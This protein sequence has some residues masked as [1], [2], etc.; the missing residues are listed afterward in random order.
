[1]RFIALFFIGMFFCLM[2]LPAIGKSASEENGPNAT[3]GEEVQWFDLRTILGRLEAEYDRVDILS[4]EIRQLKTACREMDAMLQWP[5]D[6]VGIKTGTPLLS[7]IRTR[8]HE[9]Q[10]QAVSY[11]ARLDLVREPLFNAIGMLRELIYED[12]Q[13]Q[14]LHLLLSESKER[15]ESLLHLK[16]EINVCW[17]AV[18][19]E[20]I[21][22][23]EASGFSLPKPPESGEAF[24]TEFFQVLY[25]NLGMS[26]DRFKEKL[27]RC[28]DTLTDRMDAAALAVA[29]D[30]ALA[31]IKR[32]YEQGDFSTVEKECRILI[33]RF[34][35]RVS[36]DGFNYYLGEAA[37]ALGKNQNAVDQF[38]LIGRNSRYYMTALSGMLQ[39]LFAQG[40]YSRVDFLYE[41]LKNELLG[42]GDMNRIYFVVAQTYYELRRE[43]DLIDLAALADKERPYYAGILYVL[44]QSYARKEDFA[45]ARSIFQ[46]AAVLKRVRAEDKPYVNLARL[47]LAQL[48]FTEKRYGPALKQYLSLLDEPGLFSEA[49]EGIGWCYLYLGNYAKAEVALKTLVNQ[50]PAEPL[51]CEAMLLLSRNY[52][53]QAEEAWTTEQERLK[54]EGK[55]ALHLEL[56][57]RRFEE[58]DVD[59][60]AYRDIKQRLEI[61]LAG[62]RDGGAGEVIAAVYRKSAQTLEFLLQSYQTGEFISSPFKDQKEEILL[63]IRDLSLK[64][65]VGE[66][67]K[68]GQAY[69]MLRDRRQEKRNQIGETVI[70]ARMAKVKSLLEEEAWRGEYGLL[71]LQN[72]SQQEKRLKQESGMA[73]SLRQARLTAVEAAKRKVSAVIEE[74][75]ERRRSEV[76]NQLNILKNM[77]L[78]DEQ[79]AF[80]FYYLGEMDYRTEQEEYLKREDA[81]S[82]SYEKY[83]MDFERYQA[84]TVQQGPK[85]V[86]PAQPK[87]DYTSAKAYFESLLRKHPD[88]RFS[89]AAQYSLLFCHTEEGHK[90]EVIRLG[91][92]LLKKHPESE[93]A[94]QTALILGEYY[95]DGN[96]L[97]RALERYRTVLKFPESKWFDKALYKIGWTYYRLS[98]A[99]KAISAF[100]YLINEQNSLTGEGVDVALFTQS[101]L[102][103]ESIDYI[104]ISFAESDTSENDMNGLKNAKRFVRK[105]PNPLL[106]AR[107]LQK[108][109]DVYR[110]QLKYDNAIATYRDLKK[111]Y[112]DY[113]QMPGV[114]YSVIECYELKGQAKDHELANEGRQL[115]FKT[116]HIATQWS[117]NNPDSVA[118]VVG[119]SLAERSLLEA[120]SYYYSMALSKESKDVYRKVIDLYW[121]YLKVYPNREK[122]GECHY[123]IAEIL[124]GTG[125][126]LEA[127]KQYMQVSRTYK[128]SKYVETAAMNAVVAAQ[129]YLK[130]EEAKQKPQDREPQNRTGGVQ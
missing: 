30:Q 23:T 72:L 80:V 39:A 64:T 19:A 96:Q 75:A 12:P 5:V 56:L 108:L 101:L 2:P 49:L 14:M 55:I 36:P 106:A 69:L 21:R 66:K 126:Y 82:A 79:E 37:R 46:S 44:G 77:T 93:Y 58:G 78:S 90:D 70:R 87:L 100:F 42:K 54:N 16:R 41:K 102:T 71:N 33:R 31:E 115:L 97:D 76:Q 18:E 104:A 120:A 91:E 45:T 103:K 8:V 130:Q 11:E 125:D 40:K 109:G 95:F 62:N 124:F 67:D 65:R 38:S 4:K 1:M 129:N 50:S 13:P 83:L 113:P 122:A 10:Q 68:P 28:K 89:D 29:S 34:H 59:T 110:E 24:H 127:A 121:D 107:I 116:Y 27:D 73:D 85:P 17:K 86:L 47:G 43:Q 81:Y 15:V 92:D 99:K 88:S 7:S 114:M 32:S 3:G 22:F 123:Y 98:D 48:D 61:L 118:R 119:D 94:P 53:K 51:G 20:L 6:V 60:T 57:E 25:E 105:V 35:D 26:S 74:G 117:K 112:P 63:R 84:D 128:N 111:L 9:T 52:L